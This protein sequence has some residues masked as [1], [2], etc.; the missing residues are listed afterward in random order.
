MIFI[1]IFL[2]IHFMY[3]KSMFSQALSLNDAYFQGL[4]YLH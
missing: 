2:N 4:N 1:S 3:Q